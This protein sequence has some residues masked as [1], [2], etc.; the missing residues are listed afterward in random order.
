[1]IFCHDFLFSLTQSGEYSDFTLVCKDREYKLH[2]VIV[3]PQSSVITAALSGGF[4]EA[5]TK[6]LTVN[7]FDVFTV[8]YMIAFL[9][10][11]QY[12]ICSER[13]PKSDDG[14]NQNDTEESKYYI[15]KPEEENVDDLISHL[16]VN[17]IADYYN[18]EKLAKLSTSKIKAFLDKGQSA[19]VFPRIIQEVSTSNRDPDI[20]SIV[21]SAAVTHIERLCDLEAFQDMDLDG[22]LTMEMFRAYTKKIKELERR[23]DDA[24]QNVVTYQQLRDDEIKAKEFVIKRMDMSVELL[25]N[26]EECRNCQENFGCYFE[27]KGPEFRPYYLLRCGHCDCRHK[28]DQSY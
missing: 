4:K 14:N 13:A 25:S 27:K 19:E 28:H 22:N 17:A 2:Q 5:T 21:A 16:R 18:I 1:M 24:Q 11:G 23:L 9:Y 3:C 10:V 7:E 8:H 15:K 6:V 12:A 26:T 20:H